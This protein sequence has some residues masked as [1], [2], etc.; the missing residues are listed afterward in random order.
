[1]T[2]TEFLLTLSLGA[3]LVIIFQIANWV[4]KMDLIKD[5]SIDN[6]TEELERMIHGNL[7]GFPERVQSYEDWKRN[8]EA[9]ESK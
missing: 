5:T 4:S 8:R 6:Y 1:M 3:G 9:L 7:D 2:P